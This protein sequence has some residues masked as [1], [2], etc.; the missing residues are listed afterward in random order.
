MVRQGSGRRSARHE[1]AQPGTRAISGRV[2]FLRKADRERVTRDPVG[3]VG[4]RHGIAFCRRERAA[5]RARFGEDF[6]G[7]ID[8][9]RIGLNRVQGRDRMGTHAV[10]PGEG[11]LQQLVGDAEIDRVCG[12]DPVRPGR[13]A[14]TE[15]L[16]PPNVAL[17]EAQLDTRAHERV[18]L[19]GVAGRRASPPLDARPPDQHAEPR[20]LV[21]QHRIGAGRKVAPVDGDLPAGPRAVVAFEAQP[22]PDDDIRLLLR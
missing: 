5:E 21:E 2:L 3:L 8:R 14:V 10:A 18:T 1:L 9:Q 13:L 4:R 20:R 6:S 16:H 11:L 7:R 12:E 19:G 17:R 15:R 22:V